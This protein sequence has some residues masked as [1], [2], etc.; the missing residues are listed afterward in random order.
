MINFLTLMI[1]VATGFAWGYLS[2]RH[3]GYRIG[4]ADG[5]RRRRVLDREVSR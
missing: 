3:R 4:H 1:W 5:V 2:G